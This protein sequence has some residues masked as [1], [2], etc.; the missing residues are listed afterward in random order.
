MSRSGFHDWRLRPTSFTV[1]RRE[2]LKGGI[3]TVFAESRRT[4][5]YR[6]VHAALARQG[7][8]RRPELVRMMMRELH[9]APTGR[10]RRPLTTVPAPDIHITPDLVRRDFTA[11][12][13]GHKSVGD[14]TCPPRGGRGLSWV[15]AG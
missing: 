7:V 3:E 12:R 15:R 10:R 13:P 2:S 6:R 14:I 4:Y 8:A 1:E 11:D 5:G 9:L